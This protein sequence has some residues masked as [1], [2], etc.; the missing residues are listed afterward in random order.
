MAAERISISSDIVDSPAIRRAAKALAEGALVAFPT[1]TVY[2]LAANAA[3]EAAVNRL[4]DVKGR[5]NS[6]PFTVHIGQAEACGQLVTTLTPLAERFIRK[7]W[8][9]PLTLVFD[10]PEP[11]GVAIRPKLSEAGFEAIYSRNSVG[12][13]FPDHLS[14]ASFLREAGVPVIASSAN[15]TGAG[16]P[17]DAPEIV[18]SLGSD[19]DVILDSGPTRYRKSS[20]I[21][22]L[23]GSGYKLLREGVW[24]ERTLRRFAT[25]NVLFV[26]TGNTCRSPMAEG[27]FKRLLADKL[28]CEPGDLAARGVSIQSAGSSAY[29]GGR[30][31]EESVAICRRMG[32]D[33]SGHASQPLTPELIYSADYIF[34]M[35]RGHL[36][37]VLQLS[38]HAAAKTQ[39]LDQ[40]ADIADPVGGPM[41][42]YEAAARAIEA[43]LRRRVD[44][45][46]L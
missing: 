30:A 27:I 43:A 44:E 14:G 5:E 28:G 2:G 46:K 20:T 3:D 25:V 4:R 32:V 37:A 41:E 19:I 40:D 12:V 1:E 33:L 26:C 36:D 10:V 23:N 8:P 16:A 21:V 6:Q 17:Y 9:G 31:S 18:E 45:V 24:D 7:G 38:P 22:Q 39:R 13:R 34:G 29:G 35:T 15:R 42:E 11:A